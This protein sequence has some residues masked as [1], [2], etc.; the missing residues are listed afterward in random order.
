MTVADVVILVF[1]V[2]LV[3]FTVRYNLRKKKQGTCGCTSATCK[4]DQCK[5]CLARKKDFL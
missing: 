5:G 4:T 1:A 2:A 3:I